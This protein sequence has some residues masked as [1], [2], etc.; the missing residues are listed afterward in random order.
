MEYEKIRLKPVKFVV[1]TS[2][3]LEEF[4]YLLPTFEKE[5]K[6]IYRKTSRKTIRLNKFKWREELPSAAHHIINHI[7]SDSRLFVRIQFIKSNA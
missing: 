1:L 2:L 7:K 6:R 4:D 3:S 5:I